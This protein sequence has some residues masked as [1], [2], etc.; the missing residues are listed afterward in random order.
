MRVKIDHSN[1]TTTGAVGVNQDMLNHKIAKLTIKLTD[2]L[3]K[4]IKTGNHEDVN[5][6]KTELMDDIQ[7]L[8]S[9]EVIL[10]CNHIADVGEKYIMKEILEAKIKSMKGSG[11]PKGKLAEILDKLVSE[12]SGSIS[13]SDFTSDDEDKEEIG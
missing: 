10:A 13:L 11:G 9:D 1:D 12:G 8:C 5:Y 3:E 2:A 4:G 7:R 6:S